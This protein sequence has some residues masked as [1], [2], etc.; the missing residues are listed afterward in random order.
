MK[1][2]TSKI[3]SDTIKLTFVS[4]ILQGI[5]LLMNIYITAKIGASAVGIM[6]LIF[7]IF[8]VIAVLANGNIFISTSRLVSEEIGHGNEN[9]SKIMTYSLGFA[10]TLSLTF[11]VIS[12]LLSGKISAI[13][14]LDV[15]LSKPIKIL[16]LSLPFAA[17]GSSIKGFFNAKRNVTIPCVGDVIEFVV[18]WGVLAISVYNIQQNN[19]IYNSIAISL[20]L[21][22]VASFIFYVHFYCVYKKQFINKAP[23]N[24]I[25]TL[26]F[27]LKLTIPI[28]V[29]GYSQMALSAINDTI[30]P[31]SLV[32]YNSSVDIAMGEYGIFEAVIMPIIFF[33]SSILCSLSNIIVPEIARANSSNDRC[34]IQNLTKKVLFRAFAYSFFIAGIIFIKGATIGEVVSP[35]NTLVSTTLLKIFPVIPFIYLEIVLEGLLKGLG[36]QNF[37]TLNSL[38][39]YIIRIACVLIFV[40]Y[41]GFDGVLIS[42]YASNVYSNIIRICVLFSKTK[43]RFNVCNY[44]LLPLFYTSISCLVANIICKIFAPAN[45]IVDLLTYISISGMTFIIVYETIKRIFKA[46]AVDIWDN[47]PKRNKI[48]LN[49]QA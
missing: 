17:I 37:S 46:G 26:K 24:Y 12:F 33:P 38:V 13:A 35:E 29:S 19:S 32:K 25:S 45:Q 28:A 9:L 22:E 41:M 5:G 48:P 39:E 23:K 34:R 18:K 30:V 49:L 43:L 31:I 15:D 14:S 7:T 8:G 40:R 42:Y 11:A 2:F 16:A 3:A 20:L 10:A 21:G 36:Y 44:L 1:I 6:V 47:Y 4:V 27:Y